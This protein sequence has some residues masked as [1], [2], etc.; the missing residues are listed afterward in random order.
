[1]SRMLIEGADAL[2]TEPML[3]L[4]RGV[5][6]A[7][8]GGRI[9]AIGDVPPGFVP[10]ERLDA[11]G[12]LALPGFFNAHCHAAM[13][14]VRGFAEDL[15]FPRWLN[16]KIWVAESALEPEDVYWGTALA[17]C[18]MI[19]AGI[20]GFADHYFFMDR[21][22][23]AVE[24]SGLKALLAWCLFGL[25]PE[26]EVG[27]ASL[28]ETTAFVRAHHGRAEGRLRCALGPHSPYMCPPEFLV[29]VRR[30]AER[31]GVGVH[32]HLSESEEQVQASLAR[33]GRRPVAQVAELGLLDGPCLAAHCI[34]V[35]EADLEL[36]AQPG[37]H[38]AHTPKTYMKLA[39][40]MAPLSRQLGAGVRVALGT[41]GPASNFDL[42]LLEVMRLAGLVQKLATQD[43]EA[44]PVATLLA[45]AT[46]AGAEAL[47]FPES[48][49]LR[50]GA[51]AD[52]I[53]IDTRR[54]HFVPRHDLAAAVVYAAH[55]ADVRHVFVDGRALLRDGA[56]TTL[57][58]ERIL[59]EAERRA[60][61]LTGQ[62]LTQLRRYE[63]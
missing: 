14:L 63:G 12:L 33:H 37:V 35:D 53:L 62:P 38:V 16:E 54:P 39:M 59:Y 2:L 51:P 28:E 42:N 49:Q 34:A 60:L 4:R 5:N 18:E 10:D 56:L 43:A 3:S 45:L 7:L 44:L 24:E 47:G 27:G 11:R 9:L 21:A 8:D 6:L 36:L 31:F 61:R 50:A 46:R 32:L 22:A 58:E 19:R 1:M 17:A 25:G 13:S 41:D 20:V 26:R 57:D 15:P 29:A 52:L 30:E 55:P 48:G 23:R 40:Q